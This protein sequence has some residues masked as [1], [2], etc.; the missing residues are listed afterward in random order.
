MCQIYAGQDPHRYA[1]TTRRMRINR[2][3]TSIRLENLFW[4]ILDD[5]AQSEGFSTSAFISKL[6]DEVVQ[7][8]GEPVNFSSL[9]RCT[10]LVYLDRKQAMAPVSA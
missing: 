8:H 2:Q 9:L 6:Q 10:C 5:L 3:S 7:L 1:A 4:E